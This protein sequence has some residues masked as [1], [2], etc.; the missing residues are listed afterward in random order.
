MTFPHVSS[1]GRDNLMR[2]AWS[3]FR[4][5]IWV[6]PGPPETRDPTQRLS[7]ILALLPR[8]WWNVMNINSASQLSKLIS[9]KETQKHT[10][11]HTL[12][13]TTRWLC[14]DQKKQ[15]NDPGGNYCF[16]EVSSMTHGSCSN[17]ESATQ[18]LCP[19]GVALWTNWLRL[20]FDETRIGPS[21]N[22]W[23][24]SSILWFLQSVIMPMSNKKL[25]I[26][27]CKFDVIST[28]AANKTLQS[29]LFCLG[30]WRERTSSALRS[31]KAKPCQREKRW[32]TWCI[33]TLHICHTCP[34][35]CKFCLGTSVD[36]EVHLTKFNIT[37]AFRMS[38]WTRNTRNNNLSHHAHDCFP[39]VATPC[40]YST[41]L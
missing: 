17:L 28:M 27:S 34:W 32:Q 16:S 6:S 8:K 12:K 4:D 15:S 31:S 21:K 13:T 39:L 35:G 3:D 40:I 22:A 10:H 14:T 37:N 29:G 2:L 18:R 5:Q 20:N 26:H 38:T 9:T 30:P 1:F 33:Q 7:N 11:T 25:F 24:N 23:C 41:H 36:V 19:C